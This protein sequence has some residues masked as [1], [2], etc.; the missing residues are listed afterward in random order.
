MGRS[1]TE[2]REDFPILKNAMNGQ[3]LV[4]LDNAATSQK[5][6]VV[7]DAIAA[8]YQKDN[9]NI[10]RGTYELSQRATDLYEGAREKVAKFIGADRSK[11]VFTAGAT[12]SLNLAAF[13]YGLQVLRPGDEI[14]VTAADHHSNLVPWQEAAK[15]TGAKLVYLPLDLGGKVD[16]ERVKKEQII[17]KKTKILAIAQVTNVLGTEQPIAELINLVHQAGGVAVIDGAQAA[18]HLPVDVK[19]LDADFYAFSGHKML[20]QTGIGVLYGKKKLLEATRPLFFGGEMIEEVGLTSATYKKAPY[21]FEAGSQNVSGAISLGSAIDYLTEIGLDKIAARE[22][23]LGKAAAAGLRA[24][25]GVRVYGQ[26]GGIVSFNLAGIHPH[27][28]AT[29]LDAQGIAVRAGQHCA[30]P[31]MNF[32]QVPGTVRA[33]FAFYNNEEDVSA[34][35]TGVKEAKEFF[36]GLR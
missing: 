4:Y 31:M 7:L 20:S 24:I 19:K 27:D 16:V 18:G 8:F 22:A 21:K 35:I 15:M 29:A 3:P 14:A 32:L 23:E 17:G 26:G 9:A 11:I 1:W 13:G 6:Q 36:H 34:L 28:L 10:Y 12:A 5:P 25:P 2:I 33:S 30:Q